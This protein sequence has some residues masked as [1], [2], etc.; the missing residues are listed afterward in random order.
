MNIID[1]GLKFKS[2]SYGNKPNKLVLHHAEA[3]KC[4]VQDIHSW[5]LNNGSFQLAP[6]VFAIK[7]VKATDGKHAINNKIDPTMFNGNV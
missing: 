2:L 7:P 1:V 4:T 6:N 5:H 3:S